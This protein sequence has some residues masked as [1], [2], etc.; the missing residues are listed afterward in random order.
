MDETSMAIGIYIHIP[1]CKSRCRYCDFYSTTC[2]EQCGEYVEAV[3]REIEVCT[4]E[5]PRTIYLGGGTPSLLSPD[6][7][8]MILSAIPHLETVAEVTMEANP[9]DISLPYL[10]AIRAIGINRLSIGIQSFHNETLRLIGR[11]HTAEQAKAA[12]QAAREAGFN[13]ISIDLI[14]GLPGQTM[15]EWVE[16][17]QEALKLNSEH[18]STYCLSY[19]EGTPL[20]QMRNQGEI[21]ETDEDMLNQMYDYLCQTL[22]SNGFEHYEVSNFSRPG[23][24]SQHNSSYW[25]G[26][27]YIGIGAGAHSYDGNRRSWNPSDLDAY[28]QGTLARNLLQEYETLSDEDKHT[29][30]VMLGLRTAEGIDTALV[31]DKSE[32]IL[33]YTTSGHL[34][35]ENGRLIATQR[36]IHILNTIITD[37]I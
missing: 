8:Q 25:Q 4:K 23:F 26:I 14:Y 37:L 13:N 10:Q 12:V 18:I 20:T 27:P 32:K 24:R 1:F 17:C 3:R 19:E 6:Q 30:A 34:R 36:G 5:T 21:E 15:E 22:V 29:E 35:I 7:I 28:I 11:R 9:G 2:L 31:Q 16:D 33:Q